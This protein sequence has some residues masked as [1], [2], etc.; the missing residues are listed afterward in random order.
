MH[1]A[2]AIPTIVQTLINTVKFVFDSP[3][4]YMSSLSRKI[5]PGS[6]FGTL[7]VMN[8]SCMR[9]FA[10]ST[11]SGVSWAFGR[12]F[13]GTGTCFPVS[14]SLYDRWADATSFEPSLLFAARKALSVSRLLAGV[15]SGLFAMLNFCCALELTGVGVPGVPRSRRHR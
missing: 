10:F 13:I 9:S 4:W 6:L 5:C 15:A 8:S 1:V 14:T 7:L 2:N 3:R 12:I 11:R